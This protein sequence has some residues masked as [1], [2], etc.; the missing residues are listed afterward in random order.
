MAS[1]GDPPGSAGERPLARS[2]DWIVFYS[3]PIFAVLGE[4]GPRLPLWIVLLQFI[5]SVVDL[6]AV[7][8]RVLIQS[9]RPWLDSDPARA[10]S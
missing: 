5:Q 8:G 3:V 7:S 4:S 2:L 1:S 6:F 9:V 10:R